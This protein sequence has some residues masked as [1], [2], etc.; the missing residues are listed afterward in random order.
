MKYRISVIY[1]SVRTN[2]NGIRAA[3]F[4]CDALEKRDNIVHLIDPMITPLPMLDKMYK[5]YP[6]GAAPENMQLIGDQLDK[7]DGYI[8]VTGEYNHSMPPALKN[9]LDHYQKEYLYKPSGIVSYSAGR[10]GGVRAAI[11]A[12]I[13]LAELGT[14]SIPTIL[15]VPQVQKIIDETGKTQEEWLLKQS[16]RFLNE[17]EWYVTALARQRN[18]KPDPV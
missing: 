6:E 11:Q 3:R 14:P 17:F 5:E 15:S 16:E 1:G 12:R 7:S 18:E 10:F 2:R 13:T 8:I 9:L 4:I